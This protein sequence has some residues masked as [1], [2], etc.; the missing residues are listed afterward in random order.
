MAILWV[1]ALQSGDRILLVVLHVAFVFSFN[2]RYIE[3]K[4][5]NLSCRMSCLSNNISANGVSVKISRSLNIHKV[6]LQR[7]I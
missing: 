1:G 2:N 4:Y 3:L 7:I 6:M 5:W